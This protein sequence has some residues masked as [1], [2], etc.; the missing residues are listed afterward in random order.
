M[1]KKVIA[2][3]VLLLAFAVL[4]SACSSSSSGDSAFD[5]GSFDVV[6]TDEQGQLYRHDT[7][8][9]LKDKQDKL[10]GVADA[11]CKS[12]TDVGGTMGYKNMQS[13]EDGIYRISLS[14]SVPNGKV[15]ELVAAV[16]A[17]GSTVTY[18]NQT[19]TNVTSAY[20]KDALILQSNK[21]KLVLYKQM[22]DDDAL[23]VK[24]KRELIDVISELE[25]DIAAQEKA[26]GNMMSVGN[27]RV[28]VQLYSN[29]Y[30]RNSGLSFGEVLLIILGVLVS[31]AISVSPVVLV[32]VCIRNGKF[33]RKQNQLICEL[34]AQIAA[35]QSQSDSEA[36]NAD[37]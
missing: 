22:L 23:T 10:Q 11:V 34:Q 27:S 9:T 13:N 25:L 4:L 37:E 1:K 29:T 15:D 5:T 8:L 21:D 2:L 20:Y 36:N 26:N 30:Y 17:L 28:S 6:D 32:I 35:N 7:R 24:E 31:L 18:E 12:V 14:F 3:M 16:K 33:A 19:L